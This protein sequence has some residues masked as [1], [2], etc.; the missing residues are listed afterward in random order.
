MSLSIIIITPPLVIG[1]PPFQASNLTLL[2]VTGDHCSVLRLDSVAADRTSGL[3]SVTVERASLSAGRLA[4]APPLP[5]HKGATLSD[6][7]VSVARLRLRGRTDSELTLSVRETA[8]VRWSPTVHRHLKNVADCLRRWTGLVRP[9]P[10]PV[11]GPQTA[12]G[13]QTAGEP[14]T[15]SGGP[16][17]TVRLRADLTVDAAL[18]SRC[19]LGLAVSELSWSRHGSSVSLTATAPRVLF[20][21]HQILTL[22]GLK[23]ERTAE[24]RAAAA[25]RAAC[26]D[27]LLPT[28]VCWEVNLASL[29]GSVPYGYDLAEAW[30]EEL[31]STIRWL[32]RLHGRPSGPG[33]DG[34]PL[35]ADLCIQ[36]RQTNMQSGSRPMC[37]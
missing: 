9:A 15:S 11:D 16:R 21:G 19:R 22:H 20:D 24:H 1:S 23:A 2:A 31:L 4:A 10:V 12:A 8:A 27:L 25:R 14:Q 18:S 7:A 30:N 3:L 29:E 36:V 35:P 37:F 6:P 26:E 33:A 17:L 5:C 32:K 13:P 34:A 28:N